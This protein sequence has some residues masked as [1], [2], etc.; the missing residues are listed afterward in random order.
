M[1]NNN[2]EFWN[3]YTEKENIFSGQ[4]WARKPMYPAFPRVICPYP[5][6]VFYVMR[7]FV[8]AAVFFSKRRSL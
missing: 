7:V 8:K 1:L 6:H 2:I 5:Q 4:L 3:Q